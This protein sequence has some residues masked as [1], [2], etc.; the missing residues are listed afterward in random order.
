MDRHRTL[1]PATEARRGAGWRTCL[2]GP[3]VVEDPEL[4][5]QA[6]LVGSDPFPDDLVASKC[7]MVTAHSST[8]GPS[9]PGPRTL[10]Y[11]CRGMRPSRRPCRRPRSGP[12]RPGGDQETPRGSGGSARLWPRVLTQTDCSISGCRGQRPLH[13]FGHSRPRQRTSAVATHARQRSKLANGVE[14]AVGA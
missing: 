5:E 12:R 13:S 1:E 4:N 2:V 7:M 8:L 6:E 11:R 3:R 10:P 9:G 14:H